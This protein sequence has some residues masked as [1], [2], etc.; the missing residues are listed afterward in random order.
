[1]E[2]GQSTRNPELGLSILSVSL[3]G[4]AMSKKPK[5][6]PQKKA[7]RGRLERRGK[8]LVGALTLALVC[9]AGTSMLAQINSRKKGNQSSGDFSV[10]SLAASGP[11]KEYIY[12]GSRLISTIEPT[13]VNGNDAQFISMCAYDT[14][15]APGSTE[16]C[17]TDMRGCGIFGNAGTRYRIEVKMLNTGTTTWI[18]PLTG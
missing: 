14:G 17:F 5:K 3:K 10:A 2:G 16:N 11:S 4:D 8:R 6:L 7:F 9:V 18:P 12:A 1:V 13:V 15:N